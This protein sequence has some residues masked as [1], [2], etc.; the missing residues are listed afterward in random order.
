MTVD[1]TPTLR[2]RLHCSLW[3]E[4][5]ETSGPSGTD[6]GREDRPQWDRFERPTP[7]ASLRAGSCAKNAQ[8][9]GNLSIGRAWTIQNQRVGQPARFGTVGAP[10]LRCCKGGRDAACTILCVT[11]LLMLERSKAWVTRPASDKN[12]P[13]RY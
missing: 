11:M 2:L 1:H 8:G 5:A 10:S 7:S 4:M 9:W 3:R 12:L 6:T 13:L